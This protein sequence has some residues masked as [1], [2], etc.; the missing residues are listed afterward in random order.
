MTD[1]CNRA[2]LLDELSI[3]GDEKS[4]GGDEVCARG[5]QSIDESSKRGVPRRFACSVHPAGL[6]RS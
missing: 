3:V 5:S 1:Q 6:A 2:V 4:P